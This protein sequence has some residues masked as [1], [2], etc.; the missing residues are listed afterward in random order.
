MKDTRRFGRLTTR[1]QG[2]SIWLWA[3]ERRWILFVA[4]SLAALATFLELSDELVEDEELAAIDIHIL[5]YVATLRRPW[6]TMHAIDVTAL[7]SDTL[8]GLV[9]LAAALPLLRMR[10]YAGAVQLVV[11]TSCAGVWTLLTKH[12]FS[13]ARPDVVERL[14]D[15]H[16]YSFP[17]GHSAGASALYVTLAIVVGRHVRTMQGRLLLLAGTG[18]LAIAIG[19]TRVYLGVH[20]PSDVAS[21]LAFGAGWALLLT[22][23]FEWRRGRRGELAGRTVLDAET[24]AAETDATEATERSR[25]S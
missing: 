1:A 11:G 17:S 20:Y 8:L 7:G 6:L 13:R 22:A 2:L 23:P 5:R 18:S 4:A 21:G 9:M 25:A 15:V 14:M 16:G 19:F 24:D 3:R 10:D 12:Y